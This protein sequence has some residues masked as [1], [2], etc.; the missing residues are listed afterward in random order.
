MNEIARVLEKEDGEL[1]FQSIKDH[2]KGV[3]RIA[4]KL[5]KNQIELIQRIVLV[6]ALL[7]DLGKYDDRFYDRIMKSGPS[8]MHQAHGCLLLLHLFRGKYSNNVIN[9]LIQMIVGHHGGLKNGKTLRYECEKNGCSNCEG[10]LDVPDLQLEEIFKYRDQ[11]FVEFFHDLCKKIP[12][13]KKILNQDLS[14]FDT[15]SSH[16]QCYIISVCFSILCDADG[17]D[18]ESFSNPEASKL[19]KTRKLGLKSLQKKLEKYISKKVDNGPGVTSPEIFKARSDF[20]QD[21]LKKTNYPPGF[22]DAIGPTGIGKTFSLMAWALSH[23][24]YNGMKRVIWVVPYMSITDQ[25]SDEFRAIFGNK[26]VIEHYSTYERK[27]EKG[28]SERED[29]REALRSLL[30]SN[31]DCEVI[32]TTAVQFF[33]SCFSCMPGKS[34]KIH[35]I[36][37]ATIIF[38]EAQSIPYCFF[39]PIFSVLNQIQKYSNC[40]ILF[41]SATLPQFHKIY[42]QT[43]KGK[44]LIEK[45]TSLVDDYER[46]FPIFEKTTIHIINRGKRTSYKSIAKRACQKK[47][48]LI[49]LNTQ[50]EAFQVFLNVLDYVDNPNRVLFLATCLTPHHRKKV[51]ESAYQKLESGEGV[52]LVSTQCI[53]SGINISFPYAFRAVGPLESIM[54]AKGRCNRHGEFK[55]NGFYIFIPEKNKE[56]RF[57]LPLG[58]Y[59]RTTNKCRDLILEGKMDLNNPSL[60]ARYF[61]EINQGVEKDKSKIEEILRKNWHFKSASN[62]FKMIASY[63]PVS[64]IVENEHTKEE[65]DKLRNWEENKFKFESYKFKPCISILNLHTI[66]ITEKNVEE[67]RARG[68][69]LNYFEE[70]DEYTYIYKYKYEEVI[71]LAGQ[72]FP[73]IGSSYGFGIIEGKVP[74]ASIVV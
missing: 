71:G 10:C 3:I 1:V 62:K 73:D 44:N 55:K 24:I 45:S 59:E 25:I 61:I 64:L 22:F 38:D 50:K 65:I 31:W 15:L 56:G 28:M 43:Y 30:I 33:E 21:V 8:I 11:N 36:S 5:S 57:S 39:D 49:I 18:A 26:N 34:K 47:Q 35:N 54:Q 17:Q 6:A 27:T 46:Y 70:I 58:H 37:N 42:Y 68:L 63:R 51:I 20:R 29:K 19:R 13:S 69:D 67:F 12:A 16:D 40:S 66:N 32:V 14:E 74:E 72:V 48:S 23:C 9:A 52:I 4:R 53:E 2:T 7:H 60:V 41:M